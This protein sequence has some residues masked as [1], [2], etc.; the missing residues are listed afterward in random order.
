MNLTTFNRS[1]F[2]GASSLTYSTTSSITLFTRGHTSFSGGLPLFVKCAE[3]IS[4][5]IP[6]FVSSFA[7]ASGNQNITLFVQGAASTSGSAICLPLFVYNNISDIFSPLKIFV[8]GSS[9]YN[10]NSSIPLFVSRP[11]NVAGITLFVQCNTPFSSMTLY[12]NGIGQLNNNFPL[13][14]SGSFNNGS[15]SIPLFVQSL[16]I[17]S[18][19]IPLFTTGLGFITN[20]LDLYCRGEA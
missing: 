11:D 13:Y 4:T 10:L 17:A 5:G 12:T 8:L 19:G 2:D 14:T 18:T 9:T 7:T 15:G 16:F 1:V 3:P 20:S 6:L